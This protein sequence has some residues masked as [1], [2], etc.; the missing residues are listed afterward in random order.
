[1]Q[2]NRN[3]SSKS[4]YMCV[5]VCVWTCMCVCLCA[6]GTLLLQVLQLIAH[7]AAT[8]TVQSRPN[9]SI[10]RHKRKL[11]PSLCLSSA[12]HT[13]TGSFT[14]TLSEA[15]GDGCQWPFLEV[16]LFRAPLAFLFLLPG[17]KTGGT[18]PLLSDSSSIFGLEAGRWE[19]CCP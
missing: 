7:S 6:L 16:F 11:T 10:H 1:M 3:V 18:W 12:T 9:F 17:I 15:E 19:K 8:W 4:Q 2:Q 5:C 14:E 13:D